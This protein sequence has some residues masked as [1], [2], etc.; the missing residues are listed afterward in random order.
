MTETGSPG[1]GL[2]E[3]KR[4]V[5]LGWGPWGT[6]LSMDCR[7]VHSQAPRGQSHAPMAASP[8]SASPSQILCGLVSRVY[9]YGLWSEYNLV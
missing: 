9:S 3:G 4:A 2:G 1:P 7:S 8:K 5:S 6:V